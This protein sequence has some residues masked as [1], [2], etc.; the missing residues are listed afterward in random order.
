MLYVAASVLILKYFFLFSLLI[1]IVTIETNLNDC[2]LLEFFTLIT[3]KTKLQA[4]VSIIHASSN[5]FTI[6]KKLLL[7]DMQHQS[8][9]TDF[10]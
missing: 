4:N 6:K 5:K 2:R 10:Q 8:H 9:Q 3:I 7:H 1:V